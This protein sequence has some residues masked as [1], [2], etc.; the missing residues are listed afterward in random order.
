MN[1]SLVV[2]ELT[3]ES[4]RYRLLES[5]RA[6]ANEKLEDASER[7]QLA[8]R[9][10][11]YL[12]NLF[13]R[14]GAAFE[15]RPCLADVLVLA[16]ELDDARA[17]LAWAAT[18]GRVEL[19]AELLIATPLWPRLGLAC[20]ALA[21][22]ERYVRLV[23][24]ADVLLRARVWQYLAHIAFNYLQR[25]ARAAD[26]ASKA[27]A[28]ARASN[29]RQMVAKALLACALAWTWLHRLP[30]G[31]AAL[32]EAE[33]AAPL[34]EFDRGM[35]TFCREE[36]AEQK[37]DFETA[38]RLLEQMSSMHRS[39]GN[40]GG[41][42]D[43]LN[44][45][46]F[47]YNRGETRQAIA[48]TRD[49]LGPGRRPDLYRPFLLTNLT[50]YLLAVDALDDAR[51]A[52]HAALEFL[53]ETDPDGTFTARVVE[54]MALAAALGGD[55]RC[56]ARLEGYADARLRAEGHFRG[57]CPAATHERLRDILNARIAACELDTLLA[58]GAAWTSDDAITQALRIANAE[59]TPNAT[60]N[61]PS[62][63][64]H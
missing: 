6:Y 63:Q 37:G 9:H 21:N 13:Q 58:E 14:V 12:H 55:A 57:S 18:N 5:T 23:E 47:A 49:A 34:T 48:Y 42:F 38:A 56:A 2:A 17:A 24:G 25:L 32:D 36:L 7:E 41:A 27:L 20:E 64:S 50:E 44:L 62:Q 45:A 8:E 10:L 46:V 51:E 43:L 16:I 28:L 1:K 40:D 26:A 3:P 15:A 30:E 60:V 4:T 29:D 54:H 52:G 59:V 11:R 39:L 22:A 31:E 35:A 33:A 19:G 53:R 61:A